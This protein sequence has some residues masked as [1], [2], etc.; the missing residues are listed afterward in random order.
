M[1]IKKVY[2]NHKGIIQ[3]GLKTVNRLMGLK[4][5]NKGNNNSIT[6]FQWIRMKNTYITVSGNN[7]RIIFGEMSSIV[8]VKISIVGSNNT[9]VFGERNYLDGC[10]FC[11]EDDN[12]IIKTG[13]HVYMYR[14]TEVSAIESTEIHIGEDS[15]LSANIMIRS[16]D[17]HAIYLQKNNER[18]N[19]SENIEIGKH[20]W[21]GNGAKVLKGAYISDGCVIGA[22]SIVTNST[23]KSSDSV[24]VGNPAKKVKDGI[25]WTHKR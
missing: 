2:E 4:L 14:D 20:V 12:N 11:V 7:N 17:S 21:L 25:Y 19:K 15:L 10:S 23:E 8:N 24:F 18:I 22:G 6:G 16:G 1:D 13:N 5:K 9:I 3:F